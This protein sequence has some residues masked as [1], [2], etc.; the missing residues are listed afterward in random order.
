M[1]K[2]CIICGYTDA[3][4]AQCRDISSWITLYNAAVIRNRKPILEASDDQEIRR[5]IRSNIIA[6]GTCSNLLL[7]NQLMMPKLKLELLGEAVEIGI[8]QSRPFVPISFC[9][10]RKSKYKSNT[11][12]REKLYNVQ[13]FHANETVKS[14]C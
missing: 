6:R 12:T 10:V 7:K 3:K 8:C 9:F 5:K 2:K 1:A 11:K 14:K 13:E 4:L